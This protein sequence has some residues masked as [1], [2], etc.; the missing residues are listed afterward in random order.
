MTDM[1]FPEAITGTPSM[2][3]IVG[4]TR[5]V[6]DN[7]KVRYYFMI[8]HGDPI[9][10]FYATQGL[11]KGMLVKVLDLVHPVDGF[12][13]DNEDGLCCLLGAAIK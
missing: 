10:E 9:G 7:H 5:E 11:E 1:Q 8:S 2:Q 3:Q 13:I 12:M 4:T 6:D